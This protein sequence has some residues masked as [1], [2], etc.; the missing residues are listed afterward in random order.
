VANWCQEHGIRHALAGFS[1]AWRLATEVRYNVASVYV[2]DRGFDEDL[3][4][5]LV[6]S[7][8]AKRVDTGATLNLWR[9]FDASVFAFGTEDLTSPLQT[10]LDL[11]HAG[12][13][14]E[15]A[16]QAIYTKFFDE[17]FRAVAARAKE[18]SRG[19]A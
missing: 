17:E 8:G 19:P 18:M 9:P 13:R 14:G 16:A 5:R 12:G 11:S 4:D 7:C 1:A 2:E 15:D 3:L 6:A 10:Y